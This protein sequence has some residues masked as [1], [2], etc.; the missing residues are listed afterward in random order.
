ML[1]LLKY[2]DEFSKSVGLNQFWIKDNA[3]TA[4]I[5]DNAGFGTKQRYLI[6]IPNP[7]GTF[8]VAIPLKHIFDFAE[9]YDKIVYDFT[10]RLTLIRKADSRD[11]IF[12]ADGAD[13]G[14][15]NIQKIAWFMLHVLPADGEKLK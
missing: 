7:K 9:D 10:Q 12:R 3:L 15:V 13:T 8:S 1:G 11:A 14:K 4:S 2:S 6:Q 5:V